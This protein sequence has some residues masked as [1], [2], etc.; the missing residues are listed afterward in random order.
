MV[1]SGGES[2]E[3]DEA[4]VGSDTSEDSGTVTD[5]K[6]KVINM[7]SKMA[8]AGPSTMSAT[9]A[10]GSG[11]RNTRPPLWCND[12]F[13]IADRDASVGYLQARV[14]IL[15]KS[16]MM[17]GGMGNATLTKLLHPCDFGEP[18]DAPVR[19]LLLLRSWA[20]WRARQSGWADAR[21]DTSRKHIIDE[22]ESS[23]ERAVRALGEPCHLLGNTAA[24]QALTRIAPDL[25]ARLLVR[26]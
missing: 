5:L 11:G 3:E 14:R 7:T 21:P 2:D 25:V 8:P 9:L 12:Y 23:V 20:V 26:P 6:A 13:T 22:E 1:C 17:T 15:Y 24:N 19:T 10:T 16:P 4:D 18:F